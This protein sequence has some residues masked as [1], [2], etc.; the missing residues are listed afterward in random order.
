MKF[1]KIKSKSD[2]SKGDSCDCYLIE[3]P[4][5]VARGI[6]ASMKDSKMKKPIALVGGDDAFNRRAIETLKIDYLVSPEGGK[7]GAT[8]KQRDSGINHVVAKE[9]AKRG[10]DFVVDFNEVQKLEGKE[11]ALRLEGVI[12]NVKI[13]RRAKCKIRIWDF[14]GKVDKIAL[15]AFGTSLGMSSE[16]S[17]DAIGF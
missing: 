10:I 5:K 12:Q 16:Q 3:A 4:E 15:G 11:K 14:S 7:K 9:A 17:M 6:L 2:F 8:L 13:C 1:K